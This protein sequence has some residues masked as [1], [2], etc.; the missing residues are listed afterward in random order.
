MP[1][2]AL[3]L[4]RTSGREVSADEEAIGALEADQVANA[5]PMT[6]LFEINAAI[7]RVDESLQAPD[8]PKR[9]SIL[10]ACLDGCSH[11][12]IAGRLNAPRGS[13]KA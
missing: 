11:R 4:V 5:A 1:N 2:H 12:E 8:A 9:N 7:G 6:E 10:A 3:S 13:V